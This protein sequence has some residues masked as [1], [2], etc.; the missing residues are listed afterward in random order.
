MGRAT[1]VNGFV[2]T[3]AGVFSNKLVESTQ[4]FA[5]PFIASGCLLV[6][7]F[8]V[9]SATW[10]ENYGSGGGSATTDVW[11]VKR[12]GQAWKIVRDGARYIA[13][14]THD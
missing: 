5:S 3:A 10:L 12:L 13:V 1:L 2:A 14:S 8:F 11:Q 4:N 9:I 7:A 6:L